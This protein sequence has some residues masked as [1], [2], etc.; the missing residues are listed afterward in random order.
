MAA[1]HRLLIEQGATFRKHF[2]WTDAANVPIDLTNCTARL[3][4]RE[5][6]DSPDVLLELT[7]EN[8]GIALGGTA[9]TIDLLVEDA[10]TSALTWDT[11]VWDLEIQFGV[12]GDV[13]RLLQGGVVV[14]KEVTRA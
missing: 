13:V 10:A 2:L 5:C 3:Q 4:M 12:L 6:V 8:G 1:R 9:G 11:G 7:T 14:S